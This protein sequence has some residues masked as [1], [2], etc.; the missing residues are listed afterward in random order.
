MEQLL[1]WQEYKKSS[2]RRCSIIKVS[3]EISQNSQERACVGVSATLLKK[4]LQQRCFPMNFGKFLRTSFSTEHLPVT[5]S[6]PPIHYPFINH[7]YIK[8]RSSSKNTKQIIKAKTLQ[9]N[10]K[11]YPRYRCAF[12]TLPSICDGV[13]VKK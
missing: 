1:L 12:K 7:P 9:I 13:L 3:L 6:L 10:E 8:T 11:A 4:R 5:A 2:H